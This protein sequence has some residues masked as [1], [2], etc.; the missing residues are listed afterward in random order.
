MS[1]QQQKFGHIFNTHSLSHT[2]SEET[3]YGDQ[4]W[5]VAY[6]CDY[7]L[8]DNLQ[9]LMPYWYQPESQ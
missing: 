4:K 7:L 5:F 8:G 9:I 2:H 1:V 6:A 3:H